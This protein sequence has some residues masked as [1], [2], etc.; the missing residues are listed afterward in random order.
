MRIVFSH[1]GLSVCLFVLFSF[2]CIFFSNKAY[3]ADFSSLMDKWMMTQYRSCLVDT[4]NGINSDVVRKTSGKVVDSVFKSSGVMYMPSYNLAGKSTLNCR[5]IAT[6]SD[7]S[8]G[9][10]VWDS[11]GGISDTQWSDLSDAQDLMT[12]ILLY[13]GISSAGE[14]KFKIQATRHV[15]T[16]QCSF[17][18]FGMKCNESENSWDS[19]TPIMTIS[20]PNSNGKRS[21]SVS[22]WDNFWSDLKLTYDDNVV[23]V[24][25]EDPGLIGSMAGMFCSTSEDHSRSYTFYP[26]KEPQDLYDRIEG[27]LPNVTWWLKCS[28]TSGGGTVSTESTDTYTFGVGDL[29]IVSHS[30]YDSFEFSASK[31]SAAVKNISKGTYASYSDMYLTETEKYNLYTYYLDELVVGA[32]SMTCN[33]TDTTNL[34][35]V[36]LLD[37]SDQQFKTCYVNLT[38]IGS[39]ALQTT[40]VYTQT[41]ERRAPHIEAI[42]LQEMIDWLNN[43]DDSKI[44]TGLVDATVD[45]NTSPDAS[46]GTAGESD[47]CYN[48]GIEGMS[49]ILCPAINNMASAVDGID[50]ML[51]DWLSVDTNLYDNNSQAR[52][53]WTYFRDIANII[54]IVI[55]VVVIFSQITGFGIDNYGIKRILPRLIA[56]AILINLSFI[57][58]QIAIDISNILGVGLNNMFQ[59]IGRTIYS[60]LTPGEVVETIVTALFAAIVGIGAASGAIITVAS[61]AVSGGGIMLVISLVLVLLVALVAVMMFFIMLGARMVIVVIFTA[62]APIAFA[63]YV[64]PNTQSLFKKWWD[65]FKAALVVYPICGALYGMSFIIRGTVFSGGEVQFWMAIIAICAP[66]LPFLLLPTLLRGALSALGRVGGAVAAVGAGIRGGVRKGNQSLQNTAAYKNAQE[67]SRRNMTRWSAGLDRN[68]NRRENIGR[69][70][71]FL[72]GGTRGMAQARAQYRKDI[73]TQGMEDS[74]MGAGFDSAVANAESNVESRRVAD[75]QSLLDLGRARDNDENVVNTN[76]A[77][78]VSRYHREALGRYRSARSA[79]EQRQAMAQV[80]AAQNILSKTDKGRAGIQRNFEQA[81]RDG[82]TVGLSEA[83]GHLMGEYGDKYKSVNRGAHA[84]LSDLSTMDLSNEN[85]IRTIQSR[86][87]T[88]DDNGSIVQSGSYSMKGTDKYTEESFAGA[89]DIA[90]DRMIESVKNGSLT[91]S[92][93]MDIQSTA[94][95]ALAKSGSG[96]LNIKPEVQRKLESIINGNS[97]GNSASADNEITIIHS[98]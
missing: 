38:S 52:E 12:D 76:D 97:G 37:A 16:E 10:S 28:Q 92:D 21:L 4:S 89:D 17:S 40:M 64:L 18:I 46:G 68:G 27:D 62:I 55:L 8:I 72:R 93:L 11:Y 1:K 5:Q 59:S 45:S 94:R 56:M 69:F 25:L 67:Q 78:S 42:S 86:L 32:N 61:L 84:M 2:T 65:I 91:G 7:L 88:I 96:N 83:A 74:L 98:E 44:D 49:W 63:C 50:G 47:P 9:K 81:I 22:G 79:D 54:I 85:N 57:I 39:D 66:F 82:S 60:G 51:D 15:Q 48:S 58:C 34:T 53:A 95:R 43:V 73:E 77:E 41:T 90:L 70:G 31:I 36:K 19:S 75:Y 33:P 35:P 87:D 26:D 71:R 29:E 20:A 80:K 6:G 24:H 30:D 3:A 13:D 14:A 23:E